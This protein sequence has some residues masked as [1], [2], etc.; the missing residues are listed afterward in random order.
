MALT[1]IS[2]EVEVEDTFQNGKK[3]DLDAMYQLLG[4]VAQAEYETQFEAN[5]ITKHFQ[6]SMKPVADAAQAAVEAIS[7]ESEEI[8]AESEDGTTTLSDEDRRLL[9]RRRSGTSLN[10]IM[11]TAKASLML[12][13]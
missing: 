10:G 5:R 8:E 7:E 13:K 3:L 1:K 12:P 9:R 11:N 2:F 4:Q 6:I